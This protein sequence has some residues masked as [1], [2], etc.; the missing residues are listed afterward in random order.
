MKYSLLT[1]R[2]R[3]KDKASVWHILRT[4]GKSVC[5]RPHDPAAATM[6]AKPPR[7]CHGCALMKNADTVR[8]RLA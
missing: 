2:Q 8:R 4:D 5:G 7:I 6:T 1:T 3:A